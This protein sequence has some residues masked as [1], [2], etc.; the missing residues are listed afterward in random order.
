MVHK[1]LELLVFLTFEVSLASFE[2][3]LL[4]VDQFFKLLKFSVLLNY[5]VHIFPLATGDSSLRL[6][7][8]FTDELIKPITTLDSYCQLLLILLHCGLHSFEDGLKLC[9]DEILLLDV[10]GALLI[11]EVEI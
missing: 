6:L 7:L 5:Y 10:A 9:I 8:K 11:N 4:A 1:L 3:L 2:A